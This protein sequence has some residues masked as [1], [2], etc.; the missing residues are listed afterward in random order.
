MEPQRFS[1]GSPPDV[2]SIVE[3]SREDKSKSSRRMTGWIETPQILSALLN[4]RKIEVGGEKIL[5]SPEKRSV[6][7]E[8][9]DFRSAKRGWVFPKI[10]GRMV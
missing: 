4:F 5:S 10:D 1:D 9:W 3:Q 6:G 2:E 8:L 7:W